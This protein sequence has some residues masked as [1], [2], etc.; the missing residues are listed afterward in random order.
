MLTFTVD[1]FFVAELEDHSASLLIATLPDKPLRIFGGSCSSSCLMAIILDSLVRSCVKKLQDII[2][3]EAILIL[4]VEKDLRE[5]QQ[6]M[7]QIQ[8]FLNDAEQRRTEES[9]VKSWLGKL[10]DAM[11]DAD[12]II[13]LARFE[14]GK[15][16]AES[17]SSSKMS[18]TCNGISFFSCIPNIQRRHKIAVKIRSF[19]VE[20]EKVSKL[21]ERFLK[22]QIMQPKQ[23]V[24]ATKQ[25]KTCSLVEPNLVG[26]ETLHACSRLVELVL[27]H[28]NSKAYK[29]GVVGTG[30][31]GKTTLAQKIYNDRKIKGAFSNQAWICVSQEYSEVALLK[32]V[33]RNLG[34][35]Q[36]QGETVG[37]LSS[38]LAA[39][40]QGKSFFLVLDDVWH[41]EVWTNLLRTPLHAAA[42]GVILVTTRHDTVAQSIGAEDMHRVKLMPADVGWEL[43]LKSMNINEE[44]DVQNLKGIGMNIIHKCGGLPLAIKLIGS[45]LATKEKTENEWR[46]LLNRSAWSKRNLPTE[47]RGAFYLSYDDLQQHL[48][49]CFLYCAL[50][51]EDWNMFRDD[52]I[53][54]WIAEG[55][56][57]KQEEE[58]LED[59]AK[60]YYYELLYRNLLQPDPLPFDRSKCKMHDLLRQLAQ[61]LSGEESF[62]GDPHSLGPKTLCKLRHI[63]VITDKALIL[64]TVRNEHIKAR[65]VSIHCKSLRV[66]NTI[67]R[68]LPCIRVL[69]LSCSS[70]QTIPKCIGSLIHL[71]LLDLDDSDVS[72]LPESIGS[73]MNL[74]TL[75]LQRC[76]SL[77]SLP[78]AITLLCNLRRLGLAGTPI[79][80]VPKGIGRLE[81]LNDLEGFLVGGGS[82]NGNIQDGWKFEELG[83]LSQLRRLDMIKLE[84]ASPWS[85]DSLLVD[86]RHL[87]LLYLSCTLQRDEP[88]S[89]EDVGNVE[90][91]FEQI[92]PPCNLEDLVIRAFFGQRNPTWLSISQLPSLKHL[93]L[94]NFVSCVHLPAIG[95]LPNLKFLKIKGANAVTK[96]GPEFIGHSKHTGAVAFPKL[97]MLFFEDMPN[98]EEW[99]FFEEENEHMTRSLC[100]WDEWSLPEVTE[101]KEDGEVVMQKGKS[102]QS[103]VSHLLPRLN[104]LVLVNCSKLK[105]LPQQL[106]QEARCLKVLQLRG[107]SCLKVVEDLAFLSELLLIQRCQ[108]LERVSNLP[109][110]R[111]L[112]LEDCPNLW[113]LGEVRSLE[114]IKLY[115]G[116]QDVFEIWMPGLMLHRQV[117]H[118]DQLDIY[119]C[120]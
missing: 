40:T 75:N 120:V 10:K 58:L 47:L 17:P 112:H 16:L 64:P 22:L 74:Q 33:L 108:V 43:L 51:P 30:G 89:E 90:K 67:F 36:E 78:L 34:V 3:E 44:K 95:Q 41:P 57:E 94:E 6:T 27:A 91:I 14:G 116:M 96:I 93:N 101:G 106:G 110:V 55:F 98:W 104:K 92:I 100:I 21:G 105:A 111:K 8:L 45:V 37:E 87:K 19:N 81:L 115:K 15:L 113:C 52:L 20:L 118:G 117:L 60:D 107:A 26:K 73:L 102:I 62:C 77:H 56:V 76:K 97:E 23:E 5:L 99:S 68:R 53:R 13:D 88:Y 32:E 24:R 119:A 85:T 61:H 69:D 39:A 63:S 28:K 65:T 49:Q 38:K 9:A 29:L 54:R 48:K 72:C 79:N 83:H 71:R 25:M 12:N 103:P 2:T 1:R 82:E 80:Q 86:K 7:N 4:G 46:R 35:N 114:E 66:E 109:H 84:R 50:Y 70:I 42:A 31:V 59:T 18:T 11:Y